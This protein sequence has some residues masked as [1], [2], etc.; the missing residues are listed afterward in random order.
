MERL[1]IRIGLLLVLGA[2]LGVPAVAGATE[3]AR[4]VGRYR[5]AVAFARTPVYAGEANPFLIRVTTL[6]GEPV[7]GV[8]R[9]LRLRI[10]VP[11]QVTETWAVQPVAGQPGVYQVI[12]ALPRAGTFFIDLIGAIE[13]QPVHERFITG[14]QGLQKVI[15]H[16]RSYP[17]GAEY[18]VILTFGGYLTGLAW[19][20]GRA[21][22][23]Y[24]RAH[25]QR[26][27]STIR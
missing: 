18:V 20:I 6:A 7:N 10:G 5:V 12:L 22:V 11:N 4:V 16:G 2:V 25:R 15:A 19:F 1:S 9:T 13:E 23:R 26:P 8:E 21:I 14:Q 3:D 24:H 17:R 27:V